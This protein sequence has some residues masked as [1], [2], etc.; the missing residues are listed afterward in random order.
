MEGHAVFLFCIQTDAD[1]EWKESKL[2][3]AGDFKSTKLPD[4]SSANHTSAPHLK[5]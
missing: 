5:Q 3:I 4:L 1:D 2:K